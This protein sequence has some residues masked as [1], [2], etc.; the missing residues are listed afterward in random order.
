MEKWCCCQMAR[1]IKLFSEDRQW[2]EKGSHRP[3]V[4]Q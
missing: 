2:N 1:T 3:H 4:A